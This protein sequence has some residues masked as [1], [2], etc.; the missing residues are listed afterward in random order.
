[1]LRSWFCAW[2]VLFECR[3]LEPEFTARALLA[4]DADPATVFLRQWLYRW[5][6]PRPVPPFLTA[7][8]GVYLLELAEDSI[9][10]IGRDARAFIVNTEPEVSSRSSVQR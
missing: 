5:R 10:L 6:E 9:E 2:L 3:E 8:R 7:V 4:L 1:M